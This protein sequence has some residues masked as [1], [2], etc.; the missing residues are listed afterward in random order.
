MPT[1]ISILHGIAAG[2]H[3]AV[4]I[5][6]IRRIGNLAVRAD[7]LAEDGDLVVRR[8]CRLVKRWE[9]VE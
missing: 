8:N 7:E 5:E 4:V 3:I 1:G 6:E 9:R 2:I